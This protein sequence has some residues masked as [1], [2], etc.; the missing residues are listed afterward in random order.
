MSGNY[1]D[2]VATYMALST[3][4]SPFGLWKIGELVIALIGYLS[5]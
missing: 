4:I 5:S 2:I 3:V 1:I